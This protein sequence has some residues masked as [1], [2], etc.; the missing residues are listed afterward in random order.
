M[1][2]SLCLRHQV[3]FCNDASTDANRYM[4]IIHTVWR[5]NIKVQR[6]KKL[7]FINTDVTTGHVQSLTSFQKD[8]EELILQVVTFLESFFSN[9]FKVTSQHFS[10]L[11]HAPVVLIECHD[12]GNDVSDWTKYI[13]YN[14]RQHVRFFFLEL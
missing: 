13:P 8:W 14:K 4:S 12:S 11:C 2:I 5:S 1:L 3:F 9:R 7:S 10:R 6:S